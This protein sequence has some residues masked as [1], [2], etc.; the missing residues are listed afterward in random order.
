MAQKRIAYSDN[1]VR[2]DFTKSCYVEG[3]LQLVVKVKI[4]PDTAAPGSKECATL[5]EFQAA[6]LQQEPN[7]NTYMALHPRRAHWFF[8]RSLGGCEMFVAKGSTR[9]DVLS[10]P[11]YTLQFR[12][13]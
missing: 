12:Q 1:E 5:P 8:T 10:C 13:V 6:F 11:C 9:Q 2:Y 3:D 4:N 7:K